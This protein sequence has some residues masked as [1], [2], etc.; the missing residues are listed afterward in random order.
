MPAFGGSAPTFGGSAPAFG[1]STSAPLFGAAAST[2]AFGQGTGAASGTPAFGLGNGPVSSAPF[3]FGA[4]QVH[5]S[6]LSCSL[7]THVSLDSWLCT[8]SDTEARRF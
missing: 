2:P 6:Q 8:P 1:A 7:C 4:S 3:A 5:I